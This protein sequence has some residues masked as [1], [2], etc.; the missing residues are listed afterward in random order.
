MR[1]IKGGFTLIEVSLFLA[2]TG[3]L[4]IGVTL[5]VQNSVFRQRYNDSIQNFAE[6]LRGVYDKVMNVQNAGGVIPSNCRGESGAMENIGSGA[7]SCAIYGKLVTFG[8]DG[9]STAYVYDVVGSA[10]G[11]ID[12]NSTIN[13][14]GS[15]GVGVDVVSSDGTLYTMVD[16]YKPKWSAEIQKSCDNG[17][18][19]ESYTDFVGALLIVRHPRSGTVQ[20]LVKVGETVN[21]RNRPEGTSVVL[22]S[23]GVLNGFGFRQVDFCINPDG[24]ENNNIRADV[25]IPAGARNSSG[26]EVLM[27]DSDNKCRSEE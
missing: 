20:T 3:L 25:R 1:R 4:F 11:E 27:D 16:S 18:C 2:I 7:S 10:E 13:S 21:V 22:Q 14:L 8:E 17:N 15:G 19:S 9:D 23:E 5:G 12:V 24:G 6:F 26:I